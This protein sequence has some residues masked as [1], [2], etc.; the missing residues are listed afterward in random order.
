M[1]K[2]GDI[3]IL[4]YVKMLRKHE[5]KQENI[6]N[7]FYFEFFWVKSFYFELLHNLV[8]FKLKHIY[9]LTSV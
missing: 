8:I 4:T 2:Y 5:E 7:S 1:K 6:I 3:Y 9:I